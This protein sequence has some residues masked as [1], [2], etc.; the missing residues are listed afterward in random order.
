MAKKLDS[1]YKHE[2][3]PTN[4]WSATEFKVSTKKLKEEVD[5]VSPMYGGIGSGNMEPMATPGEKV[6]DQMTSSGTTKKKSFKD[7]RNGRITSNR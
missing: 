1:K 7:L 5:A 3:D 6:I 2:H 4:P